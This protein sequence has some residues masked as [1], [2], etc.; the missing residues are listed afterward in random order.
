MKT[1][2]QVEDDPNDVFFLQYAMKQAGV[3][4]PV[5][6]ASD[7][8]QAI[9]YLKGAGKFADREQFPL[10]CLVL[11]D[12]KLPYVMG[13]DVLRWIR[14]R[15]ET[16]FPVVM[17][18]ASA[19]TADIATA[20]RLGANAFLTKPSEVSKLVEMVKAIKEFWLTHNILPPESREKT[21]AAGLTRGSPREALSNP[22]QTTIETL[23]TAANLKLHERHLYETA[24]I[25]QHE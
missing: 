7:G 10:P 25:P 4:N 23:E 3:A 17:L 2:L 15:P 12:L 14:G 20:Y 19:E 5:Q 11:L 13:L 22:R 18:S 1:I 8:Q 24:H 21:V 16:A 6:V 9:D